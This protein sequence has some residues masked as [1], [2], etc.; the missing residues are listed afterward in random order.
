M[1]F[2]IVLLSKCEQF[3]INWITN[4]AFGFHDFHS[5][6]SDKAESCSGKPKVFLFQFSQVPAISIM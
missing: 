1:D 3:A 2:E 6:R 5:V 4:L